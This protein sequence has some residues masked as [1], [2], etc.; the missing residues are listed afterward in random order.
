MKIRNV[1]SR[2]RAA[3]KAARARL[4]TDIPRV[5][6]EVEEF[7]RYVSTSNA[8][9]QQRLHQNLV[10]TIRRTVETQGRRDR[11]ETRAFVRREMSDVVRSRGQQEELV[12]AVERLLDASNESD[13]SM[14]TKSTKKR[15]RLRGPQ[16]TR[17][18]A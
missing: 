2:V 8:A 18:L 12:R 7:I 15:R 1:L 17:C 3:E 5:E 9:L 6:N 11:E 14:T 13:A 4:E 16:T 10:D